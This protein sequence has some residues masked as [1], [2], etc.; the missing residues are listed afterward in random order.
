MVRE[1]AR[2]QPVGDIVPRVVRSEDVVKPAIARSERTLTQ[3]LLAL[4]ASRDAASDFATESAALLAAGQGHE[5][6]A[7]LDADGARKKEERE[8]ALAEKR[9]ERA[10]LGVSAEGVRCEVQEQFAYETYVLFTY[11]RLRDVRIVYAP[12][13]SLGNF[14]GDEDNFEW[15]RHTADFAL[16]RAYVAPCIAA[17]AADNFQVVTGQRIVPR[18]LAL[19][20]RRAIMPCP[21]F[22]AHQSPSRQALSPSASLSVRRSSGGQQEYVR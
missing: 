9:A 7:Q 8:G 19:I 16:L 17:T 15:P 4:D 1:D 22:R 12:P 13:R 2:H 20:E 18:N 6:L 3:L 21:D 11:E 5:A 14:G 10:A